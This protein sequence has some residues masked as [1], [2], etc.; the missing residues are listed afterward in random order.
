MLIRRLGGLALIALVASGCV[1]TGE[2]SGAEL[3]DAVTEGVVDRWSDR[4]VSLEASCVD[5]V[6]MSQTDAFLQD[7]VALLR[8]ELEGTEDLGQLLSFLTA[9]SESCRL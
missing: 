5:E 6:Y 1:A 4:G 8:E 3:R 7:T 9:A 2:T